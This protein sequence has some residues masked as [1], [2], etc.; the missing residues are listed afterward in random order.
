MTGPAGQVPA[1]FTFNAS[2]SG[3]LIIGPYIVYFADQAFTITGATISMLNSGQGGIGA[4]LWQL[5]VLGPNSLPALP[6]TGVGNIS[7]AVSAAGVGKMNFSTVTNLNVAVAK[8]GFVV[9]TISN[10][11]ASPGNYATIAL[12]GALS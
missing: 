5:S 9:I 12:L 10:A 3:G 11:P 2:A 4:T 8:G 7:L 1:Y 6:P